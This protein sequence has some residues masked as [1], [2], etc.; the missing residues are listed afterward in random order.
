M[1]PINTPP[2]SRNFTLQFL[3]AVYAIYWIVLAFHPTNRGQ[4]L[5]ENVIPIATVAL[6]GWTY[7]RFPLSNL[8]YGLLFVFLCLHTYAAHYTYQG[9]PVDV[10]L[11]SSFH[12]KR[13]YFDRV[14]H[15]AFGLLLAYP[16]RETLMRLTGIRGKGSYVLAA[17][18]ILTFSALFE[19]VEA[20]VGILAGSVGAQ[21][22]GLQGDVFD[23]E[24]DMALGL[25]GAIIAMGIL[26]LRHRR[27]LRT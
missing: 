6:L 5:M 21:Y 13:S 27:R 16:C 12:T 23:S 9:T 22:V 8:S 19:I 26:A 17:A 3:I 4:W 15:F 24:R 10:W 7:R 25:A 2:F 1:H 14:G 20:A 11:K 18:I